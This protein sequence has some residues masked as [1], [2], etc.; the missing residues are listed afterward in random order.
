M[1]TAIRFMRSH[2][3]PLT[4]NLLFRAIRWDTFHGVN[5]CRQSVDKWLRKML[6]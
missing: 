5:W 6:N 4:I 2:R 1:Y 3:R